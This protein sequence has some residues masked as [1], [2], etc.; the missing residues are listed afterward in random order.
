MAPLLMYSSTLAIPTIAQEM[1]LDAER[2]SWFSLLNMLG[3]ALFVLPAGKL[4]D[5]Y[6]RRRIFC[7]GVALAA[8]A[9]VLSGFAQNSLMLLAGRFLQ[10][11][12]GAFTFGSSVALVSSIPP[13]KYKARAMGLYLAVCYLGLVA[14]PLVGSLILETLHWRWVFHVPT[15]VLTI[16][17]V[18]GFRLI[19]WERYGDSTSRLRFLDTIVYMIALSSLAIAVFRTN[20]VYGQIL[21][22]IGLV[23][24]CYFCW[25]Q[26]KRRDP[27]LQ[28]K[29]F[30][31]NSI[32]ATLGLTHFFY[33]C[34]IMSTSVT[35]T[36]YLQ[37]IKGLDP[38][39]TGLI[40]I[41]QALL[42]AIFA[43]L[44]AWMG[45]KIRARYL[46]IS[47]VI[48]ITSSMLVLSSIGF[49]TPVLTIVLALALAGIGVA[50]ADTQLFNSAL[51]S[52]NEKMLGSASATLNGLRSFGGLVG[53]AVLSFL[54][55]RHLGIQELDPNTYPE[56]LIA[57]RQFYYFASAITISA[58]GC[59]S[60]GLWLRSRQAKS[61]PN[62]HLNRV[63]KI[64]MNQP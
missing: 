31:E 11:M 50:I 40:L 59:L 56:L 1:R 52:V 5:I 20:T 57:L 58:I 22:L 51:N 12:G 2:I 7:M 30:L 39:T 10:G 32:F 62:D 15:I 24:F 42:T 25:F 49:Q 46:I 41:S 26:T 37:Y 55:G 38:K 35:I 3:S 47:G 48:L 44:G 4:A 17:A 60:I 19:K 14:G 34:A 36:L 53:I 8:L 43:P 45:D 33:Y 21:L 23:S 16:T 28:T 54:M 63:P 18:A 29:L 64:S 61:T 6:G 27:L 9:C 13:Q